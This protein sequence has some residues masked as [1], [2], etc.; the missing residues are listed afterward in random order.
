MMAVLATCQPRSGWEVGYLQL[1]IEGTGECQSLDKNLQGVSEARESMGFGSKGQ[2]WV[3]SKSSTS[4]RA[5]D[6]KNYPRVRRPPCKVVRFPSKG[7][8]KQR[9][10]TSVLAGTRGR[11]L[12]KAVCTG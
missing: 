10:E 4:E 8:L 5:P 12:S 3:G 9:S 7:V 11:F 6:D 2:S 1:K